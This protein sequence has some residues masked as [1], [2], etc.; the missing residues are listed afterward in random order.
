MNEPNWSCVCADDW[1][2]RDLRAEACGYL[3]RHADPASSDLNDAEA[4]VGELIANVVGHCASPFG[5]CIEWCD[6][7][8][9]F[10]ISDRGDAI[11]LLYAVPEQFAESGRGMLL[12]RALGGTF[13]VD[14][15]SAGRRGLRLVVQLPVWKRVKTAA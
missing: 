9:T 7:Q 15:P 14:P 4:I 13:V 2:A 11:R 5:V 6:D 3:K 1:S 8:A 10:C 12:V